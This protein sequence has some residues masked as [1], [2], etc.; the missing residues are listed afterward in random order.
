MCVQKVPRSR[1]HDVHQREVVSAHEP[2]VRT[3]FG[4]D[5]LEVRNRYIN[6]V[7]ELLS[8]FKA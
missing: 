1:A 5:L 8:V 6:E 2:L 4:T 3:N 7:V